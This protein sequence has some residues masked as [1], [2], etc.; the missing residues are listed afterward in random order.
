MRKITGFQ[1]LGSTEAI[2]F[3]RDV[4]EAHAD[5]SKSL[6]KLAEDFNNNSASTLTTMR[7]IGDQIAAIQAIQAQQA[8]ILADIQ[9]NGA[10][11]TDLER[12]TLDVAANAGGNTGFPVGTGYSTV[13]S[14]SVTVP[15]GYTRASVTVNAFAAV[16][17][18]DGPGAGDQLFFRVVCAGNTSPEIREIIEVGGVMSG[19]GG[20][21]SVNLTGLS[22]GSVISANADAHLLTGTGSGAFQAYNTAT[23]SMQAIFRK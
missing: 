20:S 14:S 23:L 12:L 21:I 5:N 1:A 4:A 7:K 13:V 16:A 18:Q 8:D 3:G 19:L 9:A 2:Q 22:G 6:D 10:R 15:A 11:L 17:S